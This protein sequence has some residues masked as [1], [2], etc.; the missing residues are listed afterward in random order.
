MYV[1]RHSFATHLLQNGAD[2][3]AIQN[4][5]GHVD[6]ASTKIYLQFLEEDIANEYKSAHPRA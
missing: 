2:L 3:N 4:M 6:I 1:L 5:M